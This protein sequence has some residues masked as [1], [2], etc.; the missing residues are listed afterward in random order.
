MENWNNAINLFLTR[1][2][3]SSHENY[4]TENK[5]R[6]IWDEDGEYAAE[7]AWDELSYEQQAE[8]DKEAFFDKFYEAEYQDSRSV[9]NFKLTVEDAKQGT[10][11][12][13]PQHIVYKLENTIT[14]KHCFVMFTGERSSW[15]NDY[16][17]DEPLLVESY[18]VTVK[19]WRQIND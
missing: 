12:G 7:E 4:Y 19:K 9:L 15:D 14:N 6:L 13:S 5:S 10:G 17:D 11:D 8:L 16:W 18:E 1:H 2:P 3:E